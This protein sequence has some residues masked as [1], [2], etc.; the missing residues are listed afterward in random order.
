MGKGGGALVGADGADGAD[1]AEGA[2][3][4]GGCCWWGL[5]AE[6]CGCEGADG[7]EGAPPTARGVGTP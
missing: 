4:A 3:K 1:G 5:Y 6:Y 7:A 2:S